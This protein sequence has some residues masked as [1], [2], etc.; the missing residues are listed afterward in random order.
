MTTEERRKHVRRSVGI[1][2]EFSVQCQIYYGSS[3]NISDVG[4]SI[5]VTG[6]FSVGQDISIISI[7]DQVSLHSAENHRA[8]SIVWVSPHGIGVKFRNP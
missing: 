7:T 1:P 3:Y 2:V 8:G 5:N 6:Q 4:M